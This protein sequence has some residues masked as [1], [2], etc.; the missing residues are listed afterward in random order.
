MNCLEKD[1]SNISYGVTNVNIRLIA[2]MDT[3][4]YRIS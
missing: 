2:R 3:I 1:W 4:D